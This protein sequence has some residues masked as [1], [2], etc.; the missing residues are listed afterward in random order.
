MS[1]LKKYKERLKRQRD[2][3]DLGGV[4]KICESS[5]FSVPSLRHGNR[6]TD[7]VRQTIIALKARCNVSVSQCPQVI[8]VDAKK[9]FNI[10]RNL[11]DLPS[12]QTVRE[13]SDE[14]YALSKGAENLSLDNFTLHIDGISRDQRK[15]KGHE[16]TL[17]SGEK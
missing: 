17:A 5:D 12:Q 1:R 15:F 2:D 3:L 14:A 11:K 4:N 7:A 10:D 16:V 8:Q 9:L 13:I 6:F